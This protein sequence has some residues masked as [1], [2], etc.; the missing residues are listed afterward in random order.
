MEERENEGFLPI[1]AIV[2]YAFSCEIYLKAIYY[3]DNPKAENAGRHNLSSLFEQLGQERK[4]EII[5]DLK[6]VY[7]KE[8]ILR[9]IQQSNGVFEHYRYVY[10]HESDD[11][12]HVGFVVAFSIALE[13]LVGKLIWKETLQM[14][15]EQG[16]EGLIE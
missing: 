5:N 11:R 3:W 10:E 2:C 6:T 9:Y 12:E 15:K 14:G 13:N 1:Q 4:A 7:K 8:N 16:L